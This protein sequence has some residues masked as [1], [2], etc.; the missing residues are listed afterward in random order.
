M[1]SKLFRRLYFGLTLIIFIIITVSVL[2]YSQGYYYDFSKN[3]IIKTSSLYLEANPKN[4]QIW[5]NNKLTEAKTPKLFNRLTPGNQTFSV[6]KTGYLP[7]EKNITTEPSQALYFSDIFLYRAD[8]NPILKDKNI[9]T[10]QKLI[11][12]QIL[13][14]TLENDG[15]KLKFFTNNQIE[16]L[17]TFDPTTIISF[18][19]QT[20]LS[21]DQA[22]LLITDPT[23]EYYALFSASKKSLFDLSTI[24]QNNFSSFNKIKPGHYENTFFVA[25]NNSI[26]QINTLTNQIVEVAIQASPIFDFYIQND[27]L[28]YLYPSEGKMALMAIRYQQS[29][30]SAK[31]ITSLA[32]NDNYLTN[33]E[34]SNYFIITDSGNNQTLLI[35]LNLDQ[36]IVEYLNLAVS[37]LTWNQ[38]HDLLAFFNDFE[39]WYYNT[40][41]HQSTLINRQSEKVN[42]VAWQPA[43]NDLIFS[44]NNKIYAVEKDEKFGRYYTE[45]V[46]LG[47]NDIFLNSNGETLFWLSPNGNGLNFYEKAIR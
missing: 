36:V 31:L 44:Q 26:Y 22:L 18:L 20:N 12:N 32:I 19:G 33:N 11:N 46:N 24:L 15:L 13:Y 17:Q 10:Y 14:T 35:T 1:E 47:A 40:N 39:L 29:S 16:T 30:S 42:S 4:S 38:N 9:Q 41:T 23:Q 43:K 2:F 3:D 28:Y 21:L 34:N 45:L 25:T 27:I 7:Y 37:G 5:L 6:Y 8:T